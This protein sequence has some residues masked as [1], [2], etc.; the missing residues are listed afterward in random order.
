[1]QEIEA[2]FYVKNFRLVEQCLKEQKA[3]LVQ[4]RTRELNFRF[5]TPSRELTSSRRVLRLRKD[6]EARLTFKGP[7]TRVNG[8]ST[9]EEIEFI[10][11]DFAHAQKFLQAL[12][13]EVSFFYEKFRAVY[14]LGHT[15]IMLDKMPYGCFVEIEGRDQKT[16]QA[17]AKKL[18]LNW[19]HAVDTGYVSLFE[20]A[21][22]AHNLTFNDLSFKNFKGI[23]IS[24]ADLGVTPAL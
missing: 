3:K 7:S 13:Y 5:D 24:P 6:G 9:K 21:R 10:V 4:A 2:K 1:M 22:K 23:K 19:D 12:G 18:K 17:A 16:I 14:A 11:S 20:R 15:H 8:I